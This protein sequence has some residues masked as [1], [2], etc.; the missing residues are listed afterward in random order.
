MPFVSLLAIE[1]LRR[2]IL[3]SVNARRHW[4]RPA[5]ACGVCLGLI[6]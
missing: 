2:S 1:G 4:L 6:P 5:L 3:S